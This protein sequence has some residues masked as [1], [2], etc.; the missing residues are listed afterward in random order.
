MSAVSSLDS[1]RARP[2]SPATPVVRA[3]TPGPTPTRRRACPRSRIVPPVLVRQVRNGIEESVHRGD[4]VEVDVEGRLI[5]GLGDPDRVV[6]LRSCVK[7]FGVVA[8]IEAGGIEAFDLE[9]AELAIMASSHSGEDL[10]V[11]TLQAMYRRAGAR[12]AL[13]ATGH[14]GHAA[15]QDHG[16]AARP[17]RRAARRDPPHVLRP[18]LGLDPAVRL[19]A[20]TPTD[21]WREDHPSQAAYREVV[22]RAFSTTPDKLRTAIDGCGVQ[23]YAF[24]LREVARAYAL[25]ADPSALPASDSAILARRGAD[26]RPRRDARPPGDGRRDPRPT[27]HVADEGHARQA[28]EQGRHG[29]APRAGD[30][31]RNAN[32]RGQVARDGD[33]DQDRGRRRLRPG[34]MGGVGRGARPGRASSTARRSGRWPATTGRRSST[35]TGG[36]GRRPSPASSLR[37]W[38]SSSQADAAAVG[39]GLGVRRFAPVGRM[40]A[41][42]PGAS[43][44]GFL[45]AGH[46]GA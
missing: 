2:P 13:I 41:S 6:T 23:T 11:R 3:P 38:A 10:H 46:R 17:R 18:A 29:G 21:Y 45:F 4:I 25:L 39:C 44:P 43:S 34:H 32:V 1:E 28:R 42:L 36:S 33:G 26:H 15:R 9:P 5:R 22:A 7:P 19:R 40:N 12:Q 31:A 14:R 8:L 35:R 37:R 16:D 24:P 20:G 30:P 27:R